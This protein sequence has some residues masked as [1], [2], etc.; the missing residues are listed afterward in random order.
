MFFTRISRMFVFDIRGFMYFLACW[1]SIVGI[2]I[3]FFR[4]LTFGLFSVSRKWYFLV[5]HGAMKSIEDPPTWVEQLRVQGLIQTESSGPRG[6]LLQPHHTFMPLLLLHFHWP[7]WL[8]DNYANRNARDGSKN[9][10]P[11]AP[12]V[13]GPPMLVTK[14]YT[15][16]FD[17]SLLYTQW[18][19]YHT[20]TTPNVCFE[21]HLSTSY[22]WGMGRSIC[23]PDNDTLV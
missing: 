19:M 8:I 16:D 18:V 13:L 23:N 10:V 14:P 21:C 3:V 12:R 20:H 2:E 22:L 6:L 7:Q 4:K 17:H 1:R 5:E 15:G 11:R 9:C